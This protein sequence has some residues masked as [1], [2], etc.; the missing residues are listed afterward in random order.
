MLRRRGAHRLS[1]AEAN[2]RIKPS[3]RVRECQLREEGIRSGGVLL[4][5]CQ[6]SCSACS[7]LA[8][9]HDTRTRTWRINSRLPAR[10]PK[11]SQVPQPVVAKS[12]SRIDD[13]L[14]SF[15]LATKKD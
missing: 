5:E 9:R 15:L 4:R 12:R 7:F 6:L 11:T 2:D 14:F 13:S 3:V 1:R 10:E 8:C